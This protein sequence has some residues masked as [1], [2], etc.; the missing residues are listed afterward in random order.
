MSQGRNWSGF[1]QF[2]DPETPAPGVGPG[3]EKPRTPLGRSGLAG[4]QC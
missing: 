3:G 1:V 2:S 4:V